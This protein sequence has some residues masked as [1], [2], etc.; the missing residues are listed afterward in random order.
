MVFS[1]SL[2]LGC[3]ADQPLGP[4]PDLVVRLIPVPQSVETLEGRFALG[5][6]TRIAVDAGGEAVGQ[7]LASVLQPS[8]GLSLEV[9]TEAGAAGDI[10]LQ[11]DAAVSGDEAYTLEADASNVTITA[12]TAA[13]LFYGCQTLRQLLPPQIERSD[14]AAGVS[15]V[16]PAVSISD[17]PRF[18]WRGAM[19]DVARH[20]FGVTEVKQYID[21]IAYHKMNRLHLHLTDDQGW[22]IHID[23]WPKLTSIGGATQVG[24]GKGGFYTKADLKEIVDY[25]AERFVM[26]VPEIDMPGHINAALASYGELNESGEA[27]EPYTGTDVGFSSLWMDGPDTYPFVTDVL[28]EVAALMPSPYIHIGGDEAKMTSA[29]DYAAFIDKVQ[30]ILTGVGKTMIG[31]DEIGNAK[32]DTPVV[33]QFWLFEANAKKARDQGASIISSPVFHAY[34]DIK[35]D[36]ESPVGQSYIGFTN[37]QKAYDWDPL[38]PGFKESE[39]LGVE[40]PLWT[41]TVASVSDIE[42]LAFPRLAGHAEI[43]WSAQEGRDWEE[44]RARLAHHGA[45]LE[46]MGI[47]YYR[48]PLVDWA[49][50]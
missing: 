14:K 1:M 10:V 12:S 11:L 49:T 33:A 24:G 13:G 22:R 9:V 15:W 6:T 47:G 41:E 36:A 43:A 39:I 16:L 19:L 4:E 31:W 18:A 38:D 45:R 20:F 30:D 3:S 35:Y 5:S 42:F 26:V 21:R 28:T 40:T 29:A 7:L 27:A 37:V 2:L 17:A 8:T 44:Y 32:I 50:P 25:A 48:S 34:L 46:A 23:A